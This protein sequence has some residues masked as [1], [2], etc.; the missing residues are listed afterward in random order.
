ML[1]HEAPLYA[2]APSCELGIIAR[3]S[4]RSA[5]RS[6]RSRIGCH[7]VRPSLSVRRI[8]AR[9]DQGHERRLK[10]KIAVPHSTL[11]EALTLLTRLRRTT[12]L[13]RRASR[14]TTLAR[15]LEAQMSEIEGVEGADQDGR[16]RRER[17]LAEAALTLAELGS[18]PVSC[19][20]V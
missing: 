1:D 17:A 6:R 11:S 7:Q 15:R 19:G 9:V 12:S 10:K 5:T 3:R 4:V 16:E 13:A 14:F 20:K 2:V 8:E 18:S